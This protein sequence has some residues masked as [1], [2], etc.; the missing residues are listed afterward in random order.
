MNI[1][2]ELPYNIIWY[3]DNM[4]STDG[5][6]TTTITNGGSQTLSGLK[7]HVWYFEGNDPYALKIKHKES[8][9]YVNGTETLV[10]AAADAKEFMLLKKSGYDYGIL[11]IIGTTG[12]DAGKK[13]TGYGQTT[14]TGDP[15]KFVIFG[16]SVHDLI[17]RLIIAKT[18]TKA[19]ETDPYLAPSKYV[20]IP[21]MTE[22][23][24]TPGTKRIYGSTQRD[25]ESIKD[26]SDAKKMP[27]DKYQ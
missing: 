7:K 8:S 25:L 10:A 13:L 19:E 14:T 22:V 9:N 11:Q 26:E 3:N 18:C 4:M 1:K 5:D 15:T 16:L 20:D 6:E 27:G 12:A 24:G 2:G 17:Y 21:Y 23:S